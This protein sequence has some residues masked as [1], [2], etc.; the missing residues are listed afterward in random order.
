MRGVSPYLLLNETLTNQFLS[1]FNCIVW[2]FGAFFGPP[3]RNS[4]HEK[5]PELGQF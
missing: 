1:F 2:H 5:R 4:F 3:S